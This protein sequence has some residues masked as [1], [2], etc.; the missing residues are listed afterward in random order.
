MYNVHWYICVFL[1]LVSRAKCEKGIRTRLKTALDVKI[2]LGQNK[3][4]MGLLRKM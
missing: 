1:N 2:S 3:Y 4:D